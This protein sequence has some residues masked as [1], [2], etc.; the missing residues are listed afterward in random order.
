MHGNGML[1]LDN[2]QVDLM[3][4]TRLGNRRMQIPGISDII[5]GAGDQLVQLR[6]TGPLAD[7]TVTRVVVPEIQKVLQ[8]IQPDDVPPPSA[9]RDRLAPSRLFPW[10]PL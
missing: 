2:R 4:K 9:T 5:G 1:R 6:V 7:P 3:M 8:Q 10:N